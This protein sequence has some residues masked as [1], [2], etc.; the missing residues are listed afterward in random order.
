MKLIPAIASSLQFTGFIVIMFGGGAICGYYNATN[1]QTDAQANYVQ[2][3]F[4]GLVMMTISNAY[5]LG[6]WAYQKLQEKK[7]KARGTP[8]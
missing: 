1:G 6:S 2:L 5:N 4:V 8:R 3:L 7:A